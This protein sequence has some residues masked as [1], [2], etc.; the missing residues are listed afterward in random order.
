MTTDPGYVSYLPVQRVL[1]TES[2][3]EFYTL[4]TNNRIKFRLAIEPLAEVSDNEYFEFGK[5][6][7]E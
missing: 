7:A 2:S 3:F 5:R 1:T 4:T 6:S